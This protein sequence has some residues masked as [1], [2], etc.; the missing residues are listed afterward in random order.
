MNNVETLQHDLIRYSTMIGPMYYLVVCILSFFV[1]QSHSSAQE[2]AAEPAIATAAVVLK[3]ALPTKASRLTIHSADRAT[4]GEDG[5]EAVVERKGPCAFEIMSVR[6]AG[7]RID[8]NR[9]SIPVQHACGAQSCSVRLSG[10]E[11]AVCVTSPGQKEQCR[12][13]LQ[14]GPL[15]AETARE[16]LAS[17]SLVHQKAR[18]EP[19]NRR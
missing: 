14:L 1:L 4:W 19:V 10:I 7:L 17:I 12:G 13:F 15:A 5:D 16:L 8:F 3:L 11:R 18:C 6:E 2:F 9:L